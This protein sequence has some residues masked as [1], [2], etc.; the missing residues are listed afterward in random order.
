MRAGLGQH[1][2]FK[3]LYPTA[4]FHPIS[5]SSLD[6]KA[7]GLLTSQTTAVVAAA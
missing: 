3:D 6:R 5:C 2:R 7:N 1:H 4:K